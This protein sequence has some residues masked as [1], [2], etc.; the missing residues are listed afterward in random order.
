MSEATCHFWVCGC[1][2]DYVCELSTE[3]CYK[4]NNRQS[5]CDKGR[6]DDN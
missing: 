2:E 1:Q 6:D 3:K 4:C 5:R